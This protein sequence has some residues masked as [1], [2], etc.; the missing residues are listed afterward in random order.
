ML[1]TWDHIDPSWHLV[2]FPS[3][4]NVPPVLN[5]RIIPALVD[6]SI[7]SV[8]RVVGSSATTISVEQGEDRAIGEIDVDVIIFATSAHYDFSALPEEAKPTGHPTREWDAHKNS[9]GLPYARLFHNIFS[10]RFPSSLAFLEACAGFSLSAFVSSDV[11]SQ[12]IAATW[13]NELNSNLTENEINQWCDETYAYN[14]RRLDKHG[15]YQVDVDPIAAEK[16]MNA[17]AGTGLNEH[18]GWGWTGWKWWWNNRELY[19]MI[20]SGVQ[21]PFLYRLFEQR[22]GRRESWDGARAAIYKANGRTLSKT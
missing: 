13:A 7:H 5:E 1:D 6:G 18:L 20:M 22:P 10:T 21:T 16:W 4:D 19:R 3:L 9:N 14:L 17:T 2:P 12:A 15:V 11:T 8:G